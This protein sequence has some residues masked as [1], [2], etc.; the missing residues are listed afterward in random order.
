MGDLTAHMSTSL[1]IAGPGPSSVQYS[2]RFGRSLRLS[3]PGSAAPAALPDNEDDIGMQDTSDAGHDQASR[4]SSEPMDV[5]DEA[6]GA[7]EIM[8]AGI[9]DVGGTQVRYG[10][11]RDL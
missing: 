8:D 11:C 9:L 7:A 2:A 5:E 6:N 3:P 1:A 4:A 10:C